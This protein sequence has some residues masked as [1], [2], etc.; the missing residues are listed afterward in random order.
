[1]K[2][3]PRP[4]LLLTRREIAALMAPEDYL[5]AVEEGFGRSANGDAHAPMPMHIAVPEGAF[6]AKGAHAV[7]DRSYVAVKFNG[8][9]PGNPQ[10]SGL[11]TVQGGISLC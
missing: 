1:M 6:H 2:A 10:R 3:S 11:P 7:L 5:A 4:A 8:N 9:F